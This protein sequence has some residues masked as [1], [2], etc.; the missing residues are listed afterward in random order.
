MTGKAD[1][2]DIDNSSLCVKDDRTGKMVKPNAYIETK[3]ACKREKIPNKECMEYYKANRERLRRDACSLFHSKQ[4]KAILKGRKE[5]VVEDVD[6]LRIHKF[7][8]ISRSLDKVPEKQ[9]LEPK[10]MDINVDEI[11]I[12]K[13]FGTKSA[14]GLAFLA[15]INY[16]DGQDKDKEQE[17]VAVKMM[18]DNPANN[19]EILILDKAKDMVLK[20]DTIHFPIL[21][22]TLKCP[23]S[24]ENRVNEHKLPDLLKD[25]EYHMVI[26]ELAKGDL[27][28]FMADK[29]KVAN[30]ELMRNAF[31]QIY[32][33]I[34]MFH[35]RMGMY[36]LDAHWGNFLFHEV[37][38]GGVFHYKIGNKDYYI[39]NLG[40]VWVIWDF[41]FATD[42]DSEKSK[43]FK[44]Y[45]RVSNAFIP[46]RD[47][48]WLPNN[49][50]IN[51]DF[52]DDV[53]IVKEKI[54]DGD[55]KRNDTAVLKMMID[56]I[57][58]NVNLKKAKSKIVN[59]GKPML[60]K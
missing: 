2:A 56:I 5:K 46:T 16:Y 47:Y 8:N 44:D 54:Y 3:K 48:G 18:P 28:M 29:S 17:I 52:V 42:I 31:A 23:K 27:K 60:I 22:K 21:Y 57:Q 49:R 36:H 24:F 25:T 9:C 6:D 26:N 30:T 40:Y 10:K 4:N 43:L 45:T 35:Q 20:G 41:G 58:P 38:P 59:N 15:N 51:E 33:S 13:T 55:V 50:G 7:N 53:H 11:D 34:S 37:K 32:I 1:K 14:Y 12:K 39:P 19:K